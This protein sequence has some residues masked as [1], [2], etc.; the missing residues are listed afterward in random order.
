[1]REDVVAAVASALGLPAT[2]LRSLAAKKLSG[3]RQ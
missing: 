2:Q 3:V 1:V